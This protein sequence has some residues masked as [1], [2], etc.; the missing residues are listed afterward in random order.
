[1]SILSSNNKFRFAGGGLLTAFLLQ[2]GLLSTP[3]LAK[4]HYESKSYDS[5]YAS[6][7]RRSGGGSGGSSC[8][9]SISPASST[10]KAGDSVSNRS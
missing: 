5:K 7:E 6:S 3:V 9:A 4:D 10:I 2:A 1:M 8:T